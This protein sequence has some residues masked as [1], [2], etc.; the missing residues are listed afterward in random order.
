[1]LYILNRLVNCEGSFFK[2]VGA[3]RATMP[4]SDQQVAVIK[5]SYSDGCP[6]EMYNQFIVSDASVL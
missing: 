1:M 6:F 3:L 5:H 4:Y 2:Q